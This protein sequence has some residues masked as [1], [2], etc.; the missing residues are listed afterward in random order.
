MIMEVVDDTQW[1]NWNTERSSVVSREFCL[2]RFGLP[3]INLIFQ[4]Y[5][6][7]IICMGGLEEEDSKEGVI[8]GNLTQSAILDLWI[9][10]WTES[11]ATWDRERG[12][13]FE[14]KTLGSPTTVR[15]LQNAILVAA[16]CNVDST[17]FFAKPTTFPE[18]KGIICF[19]ISILIVFNLI[20]YVFT[21]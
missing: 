14:N 11:Y 2:R 20:Y 5:F 8:R 6:L 19:T 12:I 15:L 21:L 4:F 1:W 7:R 3:H 13:L 18:V 10:G 9:C 16:I 17:I